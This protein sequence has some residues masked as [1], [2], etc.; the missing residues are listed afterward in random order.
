MTSDHIYIV[1]YDICDPKRWKNV[2]KTAKSF[3]EW[4]QLSVFQCILSEKQMVKLEHA[5]QGC[6]KNGEDHV[7]IADLGPSDRI[8]LRFKSLGKPFEPIERKATII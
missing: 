1:V 3:G 4:V 5:L 7:L 8:N 2:Y 6:I